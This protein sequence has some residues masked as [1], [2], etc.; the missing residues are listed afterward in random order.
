MLSGVGDLARL[1]HGCLLRCQRQQVHSSVNRDRKPP[2]HSIGW[3]VQLCMCVQAPAAGAST[4]AT[5]SSQ[6]AAGSEG[7]DWAAFMDAATASGPPH[8]ASQPAAAAE[9][10]WDAF[11]VRV[12]YLHSHSATRTGALTMAQPKGILLPCSPH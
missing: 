11:Q 4:A 8:S 1:S 10:H 7:D 5:S 9:D 12:F 6:P 2:L 3:E